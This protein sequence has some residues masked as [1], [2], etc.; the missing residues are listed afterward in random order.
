MENG[1]CTK[2][3]PKP[4]REETNMSL[5]GYPAYARPDNGIVHYQNNIQVIN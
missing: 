3:F 5:N 1:Y 2:D 4:F